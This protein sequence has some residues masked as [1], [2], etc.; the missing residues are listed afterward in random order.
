MS[1]PFWMHGALVKGVGHSTTCTIFLLSQF[2]LTSFW[3][4][5]SNS[6]L[7]KGQPGTVSNWE[8][9]WTYFLSVELP[10]KEMISLS[11]LSASKMCLQL[12]R[13]RTRFESRPET[14]TIK[15]MSSSV[16]RTNRISRLSFILTYGK[17]FRF[18]ERLGSLRLWRLKSLRQ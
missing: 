4:V 6:T 5:L 15:L 10:A 8:S 7:R 16:D 18:L 14:G 17:N 2:W 11:D 3:M 12:R 1:I 9:V 13:K